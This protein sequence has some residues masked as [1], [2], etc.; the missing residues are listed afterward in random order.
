MDEKR[1]QKQF[2]A[3]LITISFAGGKMFSLAIDAGNTGFPQAE[4]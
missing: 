1:I 2:Q 4:D 3:G